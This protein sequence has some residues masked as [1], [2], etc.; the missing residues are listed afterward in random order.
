MDYLGVVLLVAAVATAFVVIAR[1]NAWQGRRARAEHESQLALAKRAA[2]ADVIG[3]AETL[4]RLSPAAETDPQAQDD[5]VRATQAHARA[6]R[7][8]QEATEPGELS[9]V[10]E[11]LEEGRWTAARLAARAAGEPLPS[12]RP[13]CF[14]N[15]GHG[16]SAR[17]IHW[18]GRS[19]PACSADAARVETG[20]DPYIRTVVRDDRRVPY[21]EGGPTYA[22]W[23][24]GY[25]ASWRGSTLVADIV[26]SNA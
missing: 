9:L 19:V 12:R 5:Y 20:A 24:S 10:T 1:S 11:S 6:A 7:Y 18:D 25:Y 21:W 14:F 2:E 16:P 3:L 22:G 15:P 17:N 13:P 8:L 23:A 4:A 26:T